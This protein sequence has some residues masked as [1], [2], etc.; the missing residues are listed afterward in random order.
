MK[1]LLPKREHGYTAHTN[2]LENAAFVAVI[3]ASLGAFNTQSD[4]SAL[5]TKRRS[6]S[7]R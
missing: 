1:V 6:C 2:D 7:S 4:V 3:T 5:L